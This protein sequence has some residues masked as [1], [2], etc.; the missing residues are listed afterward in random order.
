MTATS[1]RQFR[2]C[3][4]RMEIHHATTPKNNTMAIKDMRRRRENQMAQI[5][6]AAKAAASA[7]RIQAN[8]RFE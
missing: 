6:N 2:S 3:E 8:G 7:K 4:G 1:G 5:V